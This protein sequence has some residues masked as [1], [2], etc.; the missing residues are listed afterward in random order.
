MLD[1]FYGLTCHLIKPLS[2]PDHGDY[3]AE[4]KPSIA[5]IMIEAAMFLS[6]KMEVEPDITPDKAEWCSFPCGHKH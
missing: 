1:T 2:Q 6:D 5:D 4:Y 3:D